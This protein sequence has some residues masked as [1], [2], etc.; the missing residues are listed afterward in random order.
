MKNFK[1]LNNFFSNQQN[2]LYF[3]NWFSLVKQFYF[4]FK[5]KIGN[6]NYGQI[7][8][9]NRRYGQGGRSNQG[10]IRKAKDRAKIDLSN[11]SADNKVETR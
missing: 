8:Y 3:P 2:L 5:K 1:F 11:D 10:G 4:F 6:R 9:H 7:N